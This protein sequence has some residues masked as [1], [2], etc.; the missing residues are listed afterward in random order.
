MKG[1]NLMNLQGYIKLDKNYI[2]SL[3]YYYSRNLGIGAVGMFLFCTFVIAGGL[4]MMDNIVVLYIYLICFFVASSLYFWPLIQVKENASVASIFN[5][6]RN[7]PVNKKLFIR[8]KFFLLARFAV[9]FYI[10][11]Q[12][13]HFIGLNRTVTPIISITGIWPLGALILTV[14]IQY[15]LLIL[16]ARDF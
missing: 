15:T 2:R 9:L 7:I 10:P 6:F 1:S 11:V 3:R 13:M 12:I 16:R 5:K 14:I 8:A 4:K